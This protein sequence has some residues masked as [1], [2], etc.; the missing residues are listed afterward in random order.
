MKSLLT[1]FRFLTIL[2]I[3]SAGQTTPR[4]LGRSVGWFPVVGA[5]LGAAA[6]A[7]VAAPIPPILAGALATAALVILTRGLHL[8][9]LG[10]TLDGFGSGRT[11]PAE[12]KLI[13]KDPR[14]GNFA[15]A[16]IVI[17]LIVKAAALAELA[18]RGA[19]AAAPAAAIGA[20][21]AMSAGICLLRYARAEGGLG[22]PFFANAG[23]PQMALATVVAVLLLF[24]GLPVGW[25]AVGAA[26][27][28][29]ALVGVAVVSYRKI[30]GVTGDVLGAIG[31]LAETAALVGG[32]ILSA[33]GTPLSAVWLGGAI[34]GGRA[35]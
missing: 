14:A 11:D 30:G 35:N 9:G 5:A 20:R 31:E 1:A 17:V 19:W 32:A 18:G 15:V 23:T 33:Q 28:P 24:V 22:S 4:D 3:P 7:V 13:M 29:A 25:G 21:W 10:D 6:G 2:P 27:A 16:G 12:I 8:D 26:A 34:F